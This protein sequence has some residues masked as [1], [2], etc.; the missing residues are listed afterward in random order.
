[1]FKIY[2][3]QFKFIT[4][5][6]VCKDYCV[7]SELET[8]FQT[9]SFKL[10]VTQEHLAAI[11]EEYYVETSDY[12]YI[13]KEVNITPNNFFT[14]YCN[15]DVEELKMTVVPTYDVIETLLPNALA[16]VVKNTRWTIS[17]KSTLGDS[18]TYAIGQSTPYEIL[19][20]IKEDFSLEYFFDTKRK[21]CYVYDNMGANR[22]MT[23]MNELKLK[24]LGRQGQSYDFATVLYPIG[25]DGLTIATVNNGKTFIENFSYCNKRLEKY[26][27]QNE[28]KYPEEL[29]LAAEQYLESISTPIVSYSVEL[30]SLPKGISLGDTIILV[31]KIKRIKQKQRVVK[32]VQCPFNPEKDKVELSNQTVNFAETFIRF[33][34]DYKKQIS[35]IKKN[36]TAMP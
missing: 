8:G 31:D 25:K 33:N 34:T 36:L 35:Y 3:T 22:G 19:L 20:Q 2:N 15:P 23:F 13:I 30:S 1:M 24:Q 11:A 29:K 18:V 12:R 17:Y 6:D 16:K 5:I 27:V 28:I 10:P 21:I 7:T 4:M 32:I 9:L 14:V 26:W